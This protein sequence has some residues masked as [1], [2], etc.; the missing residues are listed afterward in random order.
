M[1]YGLAL[2]GHRSGFQGGVVY[3]LSDDFVFALSCMLLGWDQWAA[4]FE[5]T[6]DHRA[7]SY[8]RCRRPQ[9]GTGEW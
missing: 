8:A 9:G 7:V 5:S 6:T 1:V 3:E 2:I 4:Y